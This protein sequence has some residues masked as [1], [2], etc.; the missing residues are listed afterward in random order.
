MLSSASAEDTLRRAFPDKVVSSR[1]LQRHV[2]NGKGSLAL[3]T[4][5]RAQ[6]IPQDNEDAL[7]AWVIDVHG[8]KIP[9]NKETMINKMNQIITST[10][11]QENFKEGVVYDN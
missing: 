4:K 7:A 9:V 2:A 10:E 6:Y 1:Q 8:F 5:V 3:S 11:H